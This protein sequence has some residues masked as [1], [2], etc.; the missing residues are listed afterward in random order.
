MAN[1]KKQRPVEKDILGA[2]QRILDA[3]YNYDE[4]S[5]GRSGHYKF[6]DEI[7]QSIQPDTTYLAEQFGISETRLFFLRLFL[8]C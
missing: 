6:D 8:T 7:I 5:F 1:T 3:T 2:M 4:D